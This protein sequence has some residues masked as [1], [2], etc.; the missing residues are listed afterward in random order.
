MAEL[1]FGFIGL[2]N[3]AQENLLP[4]LALTP[5]IRL[6]GLQSRDAGRLHDVAEAYRVP[7]RVHSEHSG[8]LLSKP[9]QGFVV[10]ATPAVHEQLLAQALEQAKNIY[11]EKPPATDLKALQRIVAAAENSPSILQF[12]FNFRF[13]DFYQQIVQNFAQNDRLTYM[14]IRSAA[15]KPLA[16]MWHCSSVLTSALFAVHIHAIEMLC[17]TMGKLEGFTYTVAPVNAQQSQLIVTARFAGGRVGVLE[18]SNTS[19]RFEFDVECIDKQSNV[20]RCTD[21]NHCEWSG[22]AYRLN[23]LPAKH[24]AV[25]DIPFLRG[26]Y[27]RT[28][29]SRAFTAFRDAII[30]G[31]QD[32]RALTSCIDTYKIIEGI[33]Q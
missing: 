8:E 20:L 15:A 26:G 4:A 27:D 10:S 30:T 18:L 1:Q 29:Y 31:Q 24:R 3:H 2:G 7:E 25:Y 17:Y 22:P 12:G 9:Y 11:V 14:K 21:F 33:H 6:Q 5:G 28:G 23:S 32:Q 19:N 16:P 13:S